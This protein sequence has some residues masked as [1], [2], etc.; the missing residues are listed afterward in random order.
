MLV[1]RALSREMA[2]AWIDTWAAAALVLVPAALVGCGRATPPGALVGE[3]EH[4]RLFV[5]P[6]ANVP[7]GLDGM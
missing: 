1:S 4:F 6:D 3:S 7:A 5:D 2:V